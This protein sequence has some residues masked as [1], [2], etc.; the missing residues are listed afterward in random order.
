[1]ADPVAKAIG[2]SE[3]AAQEAAAVLADE[4]AAR[5]YR[6]AL[7]LA[8]ETGRLDPAGRAR[9]LV[10]LGEALR[11]SGDTAGARQAFRQ[12]ADL[13]RDG[14][15]GTTLAGRRSACTPPGWSRARPPPRWPS[16]S[17][18]RWPAPGPTRR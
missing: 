12:A 7:R 11:R 18:R 2:H 6:Q 14:D 16:C 4:D 3:L 9:L 15:Q 17:R 1:V 13:A 10:G 8:S 5:H